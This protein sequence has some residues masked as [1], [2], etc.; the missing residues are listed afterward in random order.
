MEDT[1]VGIDVGSS[2][3][4]YVALTRTGWILHSPEPIMHFANPVGAIKEAWQEVAMLFEAGSVVNTAFTGSGAETFPHVIN[5]VT[6]VYDSVAI[7][8]GVG[9]IKP[10]AEFVFHMGAKDSYFFRVRQLGSRKII[11]EWKTGTKCGGGSGTLIEKQCRRLFQGQIPK[12]QLEDSALATDE[13]AKEAIRISNRRKLQSRLEEMFSLAEEGAAQAQEPTEF[14]ARCG[15]VIQSDLIHKQNE[16]ARRQDNLAGLFRT[17]ARNFKIDVLGASE[18]CHSSSA[19][20]AI[21][22]GGVFANDLI[23]RNLSDLLGIDIQRPQHYQNIAAI[24]AALKGIEDDNRVV[25]NLAQLDKVAEYS[26]QR[27]KFAPALAGSLDKV[28]DANETLT[29]KIPPNTQVV[30]GI[31]G[32]S[33]TTKGHVGRITWQASS[34]QS[35]ETSKL[36]FLGQVSSVIRAAQLKP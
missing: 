17:V 5:G 34:G 4:H 3:V 18:F 26:R 20:Q 11:Q 28:H 22:T 19:T 9:L 14:L 10:E 27:R 7:P 23:R 16:G 24:G 35:P 13:Q 21:A 36:T 1:F 12:P 30:L 33:T 8:K 25:F 2:F 15:V 31:D 32:G 6:Y 29:Q